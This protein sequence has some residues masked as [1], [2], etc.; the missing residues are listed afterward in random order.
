MTSSVATNLVITGTGSAIKQSS[1]IPEFFQN[2]CTWNKSFLKVGPPHDVVIHIVP[3]CQIPYIDTL[4]KHVG[5]HSCEDLRKLRSALQVLSHRFLTALISISPKRYHKLD[6]LRWLIIS[7]DINHP[8]YRSSYADP[9]DHPFLTYRYIWLTYLISTSYIS[10]T[11]DRWTAATPP[12]IIY[13]FP[14]ANS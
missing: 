7:A 4:C 9:S 1:L 2:S 12:S 8:F 10:L 5:L 11:L 6:Q 13:V 3:M 14:Y